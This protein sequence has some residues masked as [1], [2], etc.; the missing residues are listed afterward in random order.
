MYLQTWHTLTVTLVNECFDYFHIWNCLQDI[1]LITA[2]LTCYTLLKSE[3]NLYKTKLK[4][5]V[6]IRRNKVKCR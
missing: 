5:R 1:Y 3:K 6:T 2:K 4:A